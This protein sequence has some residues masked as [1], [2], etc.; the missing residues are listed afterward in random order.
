MMQGPDGFRYPWTEA[1]AKLKGFT[2]VWADPPP[3]FPPK[4]IDLTAHQTYTPL[5]TVPADVVQ[6]AKA[7]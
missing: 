1:L 6:A 4:T 3:R 2:E 5:A 7:L